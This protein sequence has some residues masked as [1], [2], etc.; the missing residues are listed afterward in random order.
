MPRGDDDDL[1]DDVEEVDHPLQKAHQSFESLGDGCCT[2]EVPSEQH[3]SLA[4]PIPRNQVDTS[5]ERHRQRKPNEVDT[6]D[7]SSSLN[8]SVPKPRQ[9]YSCSFGVRGPPNR[10]ST[11]QSFGAHQE[12]TQKETDPSVAAAAAMDSKFLALYND[13]KYRNLRKEQ[14]YANCLD[15]ECTFKPTLVTKGSKV[16][17]TTVKKAREFLNERSRERERL[18]SSMQLDAMVVFDGQIR[19]KRPAS[20]LVTSGVETPDPRVFERMARNI[21]S[22]QNRQKAAEHQKLLN[23]VIDP[24]TGKEFFRPEIN[25][26]VAVRGRPASAAEAVESLHMRHKQLQE[27]RKKSAEEQDAEIVNMR[28]N[29]IKANATSAKIVQQAKTA[30]LQEIFSK[31]DSDGDGLISTAKIDT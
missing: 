2:G 20:S 17:Q 5:F 22:Y 13:A 3:E 4:Q 15:Q 30:K 8:T 10:S 11:V 29:A 19:P 9:D 14:I 12:P 6:P 21:T 26:N 24:T 31:L 25:R 28:K 1:F 7:M 27:K 23:A 16:S 18:E